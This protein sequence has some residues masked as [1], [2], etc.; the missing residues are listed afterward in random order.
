[1][2]IEGKNPESGEH[3]EIESERADESFIKAMLERDFSDDAFR[4]LI[5]NLNVSADAKAAL[6]AFSKATLKVGNA[7]IKIGRKIIELVFSIYREFPSAS[8]GTILGA[9][10]G[11]LVTS[12]PI[13]GAVL[14]P[15]F[16]PLA[17][18]FGLLA[19]VAEDI[20]DK[21]LARRIVEANA[22]FSPLNVARG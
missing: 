14:G 15:L 21:A 18:L 11:V 19:G 12:I 10:A 17:M 2:K 22:K 9:I 13:L 5:D 16:T 6:F 1:M 3:L 20:K 7:V 4:R 8:F